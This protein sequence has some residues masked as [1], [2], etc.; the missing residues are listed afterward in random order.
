MNSQSPTILPARRWP[1]RTLA[2]HLGS[3]ENRIDQLRLG[4]ALLVVLGHSWHIA[5]G[6]EAQVPLQDWTLF[7]FH[8]LAVHVF[9]F[10]SG[11][12]V[13]ESALRHKSAP[14]QYLCKRALRIFPALL[15]NAVI[16]PVALVMFGAWTGIGLADTARYALRLVTLVSVQFEHPG[17]FA[18]NPFQGAINGSVWSLR[19]EI[20]VYLLV[21]GASMAGAFAD[22]RRRGV[23]L[24]LMLAYIGAGHLLAPIAKGGILFLIAE[25]RHV[26]LSFLLGVAAHQFAARVPLNLGIALPGVVVLLCAQL[27][28]S[29]GMAE[30]AIIYLVCAGT[31]LLAFPRGKTRPLPH[32]VSY[33]LY[34]YS[35]PIQQL[36][37]FI[38]A[39]AFGVVL[40]PI[41]L[42]L[43]C[44]GP[45]FAI[46]LLS[47]LWVER[48]SLALAS[49]TSPVGKPRTAALRV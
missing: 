10:L 43:I 23:F 24:L 14:G 1:V 46:A 9:F 29:R 12:L 40:A 49:R 45:L 17:A 4:A 21:I 39:S 36:A 48:P 47:W 42:F 16:V 11:L 13:T 5:L 19:H 22:A 15:A 31:L 32:D 28:D 20:I 6:R 30:L 33:G 41:P 38:A 7:G 25:G 37:V 18:D 34:I 3:R 35:W 26:M 2:D 44:L 27:L 8:S